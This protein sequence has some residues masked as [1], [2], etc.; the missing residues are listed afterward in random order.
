MELNRKTR[1]QLRIQSAGFALLFLA[2]IGM[3]AWLST[4]YH[5][6]ADLTA[7]GRHTLSEASAAL[8]EKM[9]GPISITAYAREEGLSASRK[10]ISDLVGRYQRAKKDIRLEFV[11]PD[12]APERVRKEGITLEG[13]MVIE[14]RG[15]TENVQDANEQALTNALQ[16]LGREGQR[17]LLFLSGHGERRPDGTA[18]HD[19]S[20][21][22]GQ[23]EKQGFTTGDLNLTENPEIPSDTGVLVIA[24]PQV[25]L[26]PGEV[27]LLLEYISAGGS[28]LWLTDPGERHGLEPLAHALG[29]GFVPGLI[30]DPTTQMLG[31]SDPA[32][33]IVAEYPDHPVTEEL[34]AITLFPQVQGLT[35]KSPEGWTGQPLLRSVPRSWSETGELSGTIAYDEGSERP[36]PIGVG[37]TL[38]RSLGEGDNRR[39]QRVA[40]IGDGDFLSNAYLGNGANVQL[41]NR[42]VNWLSR[43]DGFITIPART[44]PDTRLEL[45]ET[46][47][48]I[49]GFGFLILLPGALLGSGIWIWLRRRKR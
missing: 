33:V 20:A 13:E 15:R 34:G 42:L 46:V 2:A 14:Y 22:V 29:I 32:F 4:R 12:L 36:G 3:I 8:L 26:L 21:W 5:F 25:D 7:T 27:T 16:R 47:S 37:V 38:S 43:D 44:S 45:T 18:N 24:G 23:L 40:V 11:N 31:I 35:L 10:L 49:I 19:L 6:E 30:V 41:G 48:I 9:E 17:K 1:R 28:L 39:T